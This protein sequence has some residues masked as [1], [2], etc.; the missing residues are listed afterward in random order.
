MTIYRREAAY[1]WIQIYK[2]ILS[3]RRSFEMWNRLSK[4]RTIEI[5]NTLRSMLVKICCDYFFTINCFKSIS[6]YRSALLAA[7]LIYTMP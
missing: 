5:Y 4:N 1:T 2:L 3:L 7:T 6:C